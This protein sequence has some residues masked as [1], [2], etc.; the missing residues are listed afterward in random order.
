MIEIITLTSAA[1]GRWIKYSNEEIG[2][3]KSWNSVYI[4]VVYNCDG[5]WDCFKNY[6]AVATDPLALDFAP[7][8]ATKTPPK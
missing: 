7:P 4:F 1:V 3:I 8:D 6:T 5:N 2:R